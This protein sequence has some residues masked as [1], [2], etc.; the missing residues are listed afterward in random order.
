L[1]INDPVIDMKKVIRNLVI[2]TTLLAFCSSL[3]LNSLASALPFSVD[4]KQLPTLADVVEKIEHGIVNISIKSNSS[5]R[6][7]RYSLDELREFFQNDEFFQPFFEFENRNNRRRQRPGSSLGSGVIVDAQQGHVLTN[8]HLITD[9]S[10]VH[11]TLLDGR[12]TIAEIVGT[13]P[14]MDLALLKIHL[15]DLIAIDLGD[16]DRLRVGDFVLALGNNY[17]LSATV[18]SG[19]VSALGRS[20]LG[21]EQ[22]EEYIQTD[23]AI[24]PGSSGGA[25][26]NLRGEVIGINTAI[27]SPRGGNIGIAFAIPI[28]TAASIVDQIVEFGRVKRGILGIH[29]QELTQQMAEVFGLEK[30]EGV[31]IRQVLPGSAAEQ[32]GLR[33]GD[34]LTR[35]NGVKIIDGSQLRTIIAL[36]RVGEQVDVEYVRDGDIFSGTGRIGD[37]VRQSMLGAEISSRL[38]TVVFENTYS[39]QGGVRVSSIDRGSHAWRAGMSEDD[40]IVEVNQK[41]I[42]DVKQ[43]VHA[44]EDPQVLILFRINRQDATYFIAMQ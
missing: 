5:N 11:V 14:D 13:D 28:N 30:I 39:Q 7:N 18:T 40:V 4:G 26:V 37:I 12:T 25:L 32:A 16:S 33:E 29:F 17:G 36:I 34:V 27:L 8:Y 6:V 9:A 43:F 22:Y 44:I 31:L 1:H 21:L 42:S 15:S 24:N 19:I 10:E 23:A 3:A 38:K 41:R 35:V 2:S 20:G